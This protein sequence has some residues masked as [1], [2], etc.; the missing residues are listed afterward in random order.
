MRRQMERSDPNSRK[1]AIQDF[2]FGLR[3][4]RRV[5]ES[6]PEKVF[7]DHVRVSVLEELRGI[8]ERLPCGLHD[9]ADGAY[10]PPRIDME[11]TA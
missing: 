7:D 4:H 2:G 3:S 11:R 6:V 9:D 8:C 5:I 10:A 1:R